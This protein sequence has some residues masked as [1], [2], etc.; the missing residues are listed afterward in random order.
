[1]YKN[2]NS[3]ITDF[4]KLNTDEINFLLQM[5]Q[6]GNWEI[7][8]Q[9]ITKLTA[10]DWNEISSQKP[11][12][13]DY[14]DSEIKLNLLKLTYD[15]KD[16]QQSVVAKK[17]ILEHAFVN[18]QIAVLNN[19]KNLSQNCILSWFLKSNTSNLKDLF[20]LD[21]L[22]DTSVSNDK[23]KAKFIA[24]FLQNANSAQS[25]KILKY[26]QKAQGSFCLNTSY[27]KNLIK[28]KA[29]MSTLD[30]LL[31]HPTQITDAGFSITQLREFLFA[32]P[33]C[34]IR[35]KIIN[36]L[37]IFGE[38]AQPTRQQNLLK[39][40]IK[41]F[42]HQV[43]NQNGNTILHELALNQYEQALTDFLEN[44]CK[45]N[46]LLNQQG[47]SIWHI[48][49]KN[50][51]F[52]VIQLFVQK[53]KNLDI[54]NV[55]GLTP[56]A[57]AVIKGHVLLA[58]LLNKSGAQVDGFIDDAGRTLLQ[59]SIVQKK[60][61]LLQDCLASGASIEATDMQGYTAFYYAL[62]QSDLPALDILMAQSK[63][64]HCNLGV[65]D[66]HNA[67]SK[68]DVEVIEKILDYGIQD[69]NLNNQ[70]HTALDIALAY[71]NKAA[72]KFLKERGFISFLSEEPFSLKSDF[73]SHYK[74]QITQKHKGAK[75]LSLTVCELDSAG[76]I[77][78][79]AQ[80]LPW[81][82]RQQT[83]TAAGQWLVVQQPQH[84]LLW[85][86]SK[87]T[88]DRPDAILQLTKAGNLTLNFANLP[89]SKLTVQSDAAL[90]VGALAC[91]GEFNL[92]LQA[93]HMEKG[94]QLLNGT[95]LS[96]NAQNIYLAGLIAYEN[97][98]FNASQALY[99]NGQILANQLH[100]HTQVLL[101]HGR[102]MVKT[103]FDVQV[104]GLFTNHG[105]W[106]S[107]Q[108]GKVS[109]H[110]MHLERDSVFMA[111][112]GTLRLYAKTK[113]EHVGV[114]VS[115]HSSIEA[116]LLINHQS[117]ALVKS[118]SAQL[119][120]PQ[121]NQSGFVIIGQKSSLSHID[122]A[123]N[124]LYAGANI[125]EVSNCIA[126]PVAAQFKGGL[127]IAKTLYRSAELLYRVAQGNQDISQTELVSL[128][129]DNII[130]SF[131]L[132]FSQQEKAKLLVN[133]LYHFYSAYTSEEV[134]VQK[135]LNAIEAIMRSVALGAD[136]L[137]L[138][139]QVQWLQQAAIMVKHSRYTLK[140]AEV[141]VATYQAL[142]SNDQNEIDNAWSTMTSVAEMAFRES[143]Y[144]LA[145][146]Q[147]FGMALPVKPKDMVLFILNKGHTSEQLLQSM[148]YG[149]LHMASRAGLF[150]DPNLEQHLQFL[151]QLYLKSGQ[152]QHLYQR[153]QNQGLSLS[154]LT[155]EMLSS[156]IVFMRYYHSQQR[157]NQSILEPENEP[158]QAAI[159]EPEQ[160]DAEL[161]EAPSA[162]ENT[163]TLSEPL[164]EEVT[165][166]PE[167]IDEPIADTEESE[168]QASSSNEMLDEK[169]LD[170][171][172]DE[173]RQAFIEESIKPIRDA[174]KEIKPPEKESLVLPIRE[175]IEGQLSESKTQ[176]SVPAN[177][178]D[179]VIK[180]LIEVQR[181]LNGDY[182]K[183]GYLGA[184]ASALHNE[185]MVDA[186]GDI[187]FHLSES[188]TNNAQLMSTHNINISGLDV[189]RRKSDQTLINTEFS[190]H[191]NSQF[192]NFESGVIS[193]QDALFY[194]CVG[195][196]ENEGICVGV[197]GVKAIAT[198][199]V[200]NYQQG[201][202]ISSEDVELFCDK[203]SENAG[204]IFGKHVRFE[205]TDSGAIN[206]GTIIGVEQ[207]RMIS[208]QVASH[209]SGTL[210]SKRVSFESKETNKQGSIQAS[211]VETRDYQAENPDRVNWELGEHDAVG[212]LLLN[213]PAALHHTL[214][215]FNQTNMVDLTVDQN[216]VQPESTLLDIDPNFSNTFQ[217]HLPENQMIPI[218]QLPQASSKATII[219]DAPGGVLYSVTDK[220]NEVLS[221]L[222]F[223]GEEFNYSYASTTF[224]QPALFDVTL[225]QGLEK[226][227]EHAYA[228]AD[229]EL[230]FKEGALIQAKLLDH[231]GYLHSDK[232]ISWNVDKVANKTQIE[233]Y[234][235]TFH[236]SLKNP[237][238]EPCVSTKVAPNT[239]KIWALGHT[240]Y[241][242]SLYQNGGSFLSG[243]EGNYV[244]CGENYSEAL[245]L[246][247]GQ[248]VSD[249]LS[250]LGRNW[251]HRPF[252]HNASIG[253][254]GVNN[255]LCLGKFTE[256]GLDTWG[257]KG[258]NVFTQGP[259]ETI[260]KR[261]SYTIDELLS[262]KKSGKINGVDHPEQTH[263][264]VTQS[265]L[266]SN[267]GSVQYIST[268]GKID[269]KNVVMASGQSYVLM[270]KDGVSI[271]AVHTHLH[272]K[273]C[274]KAK[275][276]F[277]TK[278]YKADNDVTEVHSPILLVGGD[279][280]VRS[281]G[282]HTVGLKAHVQGYADIVAHTVT[283]DGEAKK[284]TSRYSVTE[285]AIG[286]P[287]ENLFKILND[288]NARAIFNNILQSLGWDQ[289][290]LKTLL[291]TDSVAK[292]EKPLL[293]TAS[294]AWDF[295]ALIAT[296]CEAYSESP[297][298]FFFTFTD[299][300]GIT[301][302][303]GSG[304]HM[305]NPR[306]SFDV[307]QSKSASHS[308]QMIATDFYVG[309]DFRLQ[310]RQ[311]FLLNGAKIDAENVHIFLTDSLK[312][313]SAVDTQYS[314]NTTQSA[315]V[316]VNPLNYTDFGGR[317]SYSRT[318]EKTSTS[319]LAKVKG[320]NKTFVTAENS[321][322]GELKVVGKKGGNLSTASLLLVSTQNTREMRH[323]S[324]GGHADTSG[325]F[326][327]HFEHQHE[328]S[329]ETQTAGVFFFGKGNVETDSADLVRGSVI[330]TNHLSR[331]DGQEGLPNLTGSDAVDSNFSNRI[332]FSGGHSSDRDKGESELDYSSTVTLQHASV[333]ANNVEGHQLAGT[334]INTDRSKQREEI[335][336]GE[337]GFALAAQSRNKD[338]VRKEA[339][340]IDRQFIHREPQKQRSAP[341]NA[342]ITTPALDAALTSNNDGSTAVSPD[343]GFDVQTLVA[344]AQ[345][346]GAIINHLEQE[347]RNGVSNLAVPSNVNEPIPFSSM[348]GKTADFSPM[349]ISHS[350]PTS[351]QSS[352][353]SGFNELLFSEASNGNWARATDSSTVVSPDS[354]FDVQALVAN[355]QR[356]GAIV[357][358]LEQ[359]H[360]NNA[361]TL[362]ELAAQSNANEPIAPFSPIAGKTADFS[363]M[364][365]SHSSPTSKQSSAA[366]G[367][368][369]L[370]FSEVSN[371]NWARA[372]ATDSSAANRR[373]QE[374]FFAKAVKINNA[375]YLAEQA[376]RMGFH[377]D[378]PILSRTSPWDTRFISDQVINIIYEIPNAELYLR[379]LTV[380]EQQKFYKEVD[381]FLALSDEQRNLLLQGKSNNKNKLID[382]TIEFIK[383]FNP[384]AEAQAN[385]V[386]PAKLALSA[387]AFI[388]TMLINKY[389][390]NLSEEETRESVDYF[391]N[392][393]NQK[394][395]K[396]QKSKALTPQEQESL[397]RPLITP[398]DTEN[399]IT[400]LPG[401][402]EPAP[403][404]ENTVFPI[405]D[406]QGPN[407]YINP[408][409]DEE[410]RQLLER[411]YY[412][413]LLG[414]VSPLF[415]LYYNRLYD[416]VYPKH[417]Q[418]KSG[419]A[420]FKD[421]S[422]NPIK[423]KEEGQKLLDSAIK[424]PG[425][426]YL[427]QCYEKKVI[428]FRSSNDGYYHA[429]EEKQP[430][431]FV[432]KEA[433][434]QW[435]AEGLLTDKEIRKL[436]KQKV[437]KE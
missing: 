96:V 18:D 246:H 43:F 63:T 30:I 258:N 373:G 152:W 53:Q 297:T 129:L 141:S 352:A 140:V 187:G 367:F 160:Q 65:L 174:L 238:L 132:G 139:E 272:Q 74:I 336:R 413:P 87:T 358:H 370:L 179:T 16:K 351:Q 356:Q 231:E 52:K 416:D 415:F 248:R 94:S 173:E 365:T 48:A 288:N 322:E 203:I 146:E 259:I 386:L 128:V 19:D 426:T 377:A 101:N 199:I 382:N 84:C 242:G 193:A 114:M 143:L 437:N 425:K 202:I 88:Q 201:K 72:T 402:T 411:P 350:S 186:V 144:H 430:V 230:Y 372:T 118:V 39:W 320:R 169:A 175:I 249:N 305:I 235:Q 424:V 197:K 244:V 316:T 60:H 401:N 295:A 395:E 427:V 329:K 270:S 429:Y 334:G 268:E 324:V 361:P 247:A 150:E 393:S 178:L 111:Q 312:A 161:Q 183:H 302:P 327:G 286:L 284:R 85:L 236:H 119:N 26:I 190:T 374:A 180:S 61:Q 262:Q 170:G 208:K 387:A 321:I 346:Q 121:V 120:A 106:M 86:K 250:D 40:L 330:D 290:E 142:Q 93:L 9:R 323:N 110:V 309:G 8:Y 315:G 123:L 69:N 12:L 89:K 1:M 205:G 64:V 102:V 353:A 435:K 347:H 431:D 420:R 296:A 363:P 55:D 213:Q 432:P 275:K 335:F 78:S 252:F 287:G 308:S 278:I 165:P 281:P 436:K 218:W 124:C 229:T 276:F 184:F 148:L 232:K 136:M 59:K 381:E 344:N 192:K 299:K 326:G 22:L 62:M 27:I 54:L 253:S 317:A 168:Q 226:K 149:S 117:G 388:G 233:E 300:M 241:I 56:W 209:N 115:Q 311:L 23:I 57:V 237:V 366:S 222:Y 384:I 153:Y 176:Q 378:A 228:S 282:F 167:P 122:M 51:T 301:A 71:K 75:G 210:N 418:T 177:T 15:L 325:T 79:R 34:I 342:S 151:I 369:K 5:A 380:D 181:A 364:P 189:N 383:A 417:K 125:A 264:V 343:S 263:E 408:V 188:G 171:F 304:G 285:Y 131:S 397:S 77:M 260:V 36:T 37:N 116:G 109:A 349:P 391:K 274:Y 207:I 341:S 214:D 338:T 409:I 31:N 81:A 98:K 83:K 403:Q 13:L 392:A 67:A 256:A 399:N 70:R 58:T 92:K 90:T 21:F 166:E 419:K 406:N 3:K 156:F 10:K 135:S 215:A 279:F 375:E 332:G 194:T 100:S 24:V 333:F 95:Q 33:K 357:N 11:T 154:S 225:M 127:L 4:S 99:Q 265:Y 14:A 212:G 354:G 280:V 410:T 412:G 331:K 2:N 220:P 217:L 196:I 434:K 433:W 126:T 421:A 138:N 6:Q 206:S 185:G 82:N 162:D 80:L 313:T 164:V 182:A 191:I 17:I 47:Q 20:S 389:M 29:E 108:D 394:E 385:V 195:L 41:P 25:N 266:S 68:D 255:F 46:D 240:G 362:A 42:Y 289:N 360:R 211:L 91:I 405:A 221:S 137:A 303:D 163:Q 318:T 7:I 223:T 267:D 158:E 292:L 310:G 398:I 390:E 45:S 404:F 291:N 35:N 337:G 345:R 400:I 254:E 66:L 271:K 157:L 219:L 283:F 294:N 368:N 257:D 359:E 379:Q 243:E 340:C 277:H 159:L 155:Q 38:L 216:W 307:R 198:R 339:Q 396:K 428:I 269:L 172:T 49:A 371:G 28:H 76:K 73:T 376:Q 134:M 113:I 112:Q 251:Y 204:F 104:D 261:A 319:Q 97:V 423:T 348:A 224:Q 314:K 44:D 227:H 414:I 245:L 103:A 422:V 273:Y 130:P 298:E 145:P 239:G 407:I 50:N 355:A 32:Q 234:T 133:I 147:L 306:I 107:A 293:N 200:N 328:S 105:E